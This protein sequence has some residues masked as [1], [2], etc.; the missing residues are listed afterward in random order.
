MSLES[1]DQTPPIRLRRRSRFNQQMLPVDQITDANLTPLHVSTRITIG[2]R[3]LKEMKLSLVKDW[4][5]RVVLV[6]A[7]GR[8]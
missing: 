3:Q 5:T 2:V 7:G 4:T 1:S 6:S 8:K